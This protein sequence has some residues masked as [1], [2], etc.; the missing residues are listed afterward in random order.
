MLIFWIICAL[1][2]L[3]ALWFVLPPFFE[4]GK[5]NERDE[6][7]AANL[8]VYKDQNQEL[9]ADLRN[10]LMGPEQYRRPKTSWS[11][12]SSMISSRLLT[13]PAMLPRPSRGS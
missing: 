4:T 2:V 6:P 7:R 3:L 10:G 8:L 11:A 9:E 12:A 13:N 1:F 5:K